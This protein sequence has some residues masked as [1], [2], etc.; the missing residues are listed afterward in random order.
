MSVDAWITVTFAEPVASVKTPNAFTHQMT[1]PLRDLGLDASG[2]ALSMIDTYELPLVSAPSE[3][4][5]WQRQI[6]EAEYLSIV[7][8]ANIEA[9]GQKHAGLQFMLD[10]RNTPGRSSDYG[11]VMQ[12]FDLVAE[13]ARGNIAVNYLFSVAD[14]G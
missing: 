4:P 2:S 13:F 1:L 12:L 11:Q 6:T 7:G 5:D 10:W 8:P 3:L 14:M 9:L